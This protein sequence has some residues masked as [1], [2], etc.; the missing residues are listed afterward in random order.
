VS[1]TN[2]RQKGHFVHVESTKNFIERESQ[3]Y[4]P[5]RLLFLFEL[6]VVRSEDILISHKIRVIILQLPELGGKSKS[7]DR[8]AM[9]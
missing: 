8:I 1:G 7:S 2:K 9:V 4:I 6:L 3:K 5:L